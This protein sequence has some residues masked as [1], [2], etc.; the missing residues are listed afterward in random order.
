MD[1]Q[2]GWKRPRRYVPENA[3]IPEMSGGGERTNDFFEGGLVGLL[4]ARRVPV[5][6]TW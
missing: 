6:I 3:E 4:D 5:I 1:I 2:Q